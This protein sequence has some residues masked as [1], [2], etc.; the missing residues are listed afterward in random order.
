MQDVGLTGPRSAFTQPS[1]HLVSGQTAYCEVRAG[2]QLCTHDGSVPYLKVPSLLLGLDG[3]GWVSSMPRC[4]SRLAM[5]QRRTSTWE[6]DT[7]MEGSEWPLDGLGS[8][9]CHSNDCSNVT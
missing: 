6:E 2:T 1:R 5:E 3:G 7:G 8:L 9:E 4:Q